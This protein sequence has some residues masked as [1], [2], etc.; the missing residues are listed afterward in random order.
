MADY[1]DK[2]AIIIGNSEYSLTP[3]MVSLPGV[4]EDVRMMT[5]RMSEGGYKVEVIKNSRDILGDVKRVMNN[6]PVGSV[7]HLQVSF[8]GELIT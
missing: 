6:T 2:L 1:N 4:E 5:A 7:A 8:S 3:N